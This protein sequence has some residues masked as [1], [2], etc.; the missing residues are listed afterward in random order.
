MNNNYLLLED[1][2]K[3]ACSQYREELREREE[4]VSRFEKSSRTMTLEMK[5]MEAS[6]KQLNHELVKLRN[7]EH[8]QNDPVT[9]D[10]TNDALVSKLQRENARLD[11]ELSQA[12]RRIAELERIR[13]QQHQQQLPPRESQSQQQKRRPRI[14]P[15][16]QQQR[17]PSSKKVLPRLSNN[18]G[19]GKHRHWATSA[20]PLTIR[21]RTTTSSYKK[22]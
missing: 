11:D 18:S 20:S 5:E 15:Q 12:L 8:I 2:H 4:S 22:H 17:R 14:H 16:Q 6:V 21:R 7:S 9:R 1:A 10:E 13:E 19:S 3:H